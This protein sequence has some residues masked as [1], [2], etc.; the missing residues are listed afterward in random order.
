MW[1][2]SAN[3][4]PWKSQPLINT[5]AETALTKVTWR[6]ATQARRCLIPATGFYEWISVDGKKYPMLF[7][8]SEPLFS[9]AGVWQEFVREDRTV[10]CVSVVTTDANASVSK[11]H[12][13]MPLIL[14][15][16]DHGDW[17]GT[18]DNPRL[19]SLLESTPGTLSSRPVSTA[20]NRGL[21]RDSSLLIA[22]WSLDD[23][24]TKQG[25]LW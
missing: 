24:T 2:A 11:I 13:R 5:K 15:K 3:R 6:E 21:C 10:T 7:S 17:L 14:D 23:V 9:M 19:L 16:R 4:D 12:T 25:S 1:E 22:D 20:L 8:C 18:R